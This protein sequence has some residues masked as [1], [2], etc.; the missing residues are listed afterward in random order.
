MSATRKYREQEEISRAALPRMIEAAAEQYALPRA[1]VRLLAKS[2][3]DAGTQDETFLRALRSV[4]A[5]LPRTLRRM[6]AAPLQAALQEAAQA[7]LLSGIASHPWHKR[8]KK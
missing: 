1:A 3:L 2:A 5:G 6:P 7:S 8:K 4:A